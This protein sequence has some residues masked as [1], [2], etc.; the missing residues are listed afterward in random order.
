MPPAEQA[1]PATLPP[2]VTINVPQAAPPVPTVAD[3]EYLT[4][5][6][7]LSL[8]EQA[9]RE[10]K[11]KL[12]P[13]MQQF[14]A[15]VTELQADK[16]ARVAADEQ[17][18][19]AAEAHAEEQRLADLSALQRLEESQQQTNAEIQ[20][21]RDE[22]ERERLLREK[23]TQFAQLETYRYE[24]L[25]AEQDAIAPQFVDFVQGG[26]RDAIDA[27]ID[28]VKA[29]TAE[30]V[31]EVQGA[32]LQN[33]RQA[34]PGVTGAPPVDQQGQ[35][36]QQQETLS[37]D[38]IRGMSMEEYSARRSQLLGAASSRVAESG[39]GG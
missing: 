9:R 39:Y 11:D 37:V 12:Y 1:P 24:R 7:A 13:Q 21:L 22:A 38:D 15:T 19:L 23:E 2:G 25:Q 30:I 20:R 16:E 14:Q 28:R 31:A 17:A 6:Q 8:V 29:K 4:R 27:S 26:S 10:E 36:N 18:R 35:F 33:R 5:E 3:G 34:A 32:S